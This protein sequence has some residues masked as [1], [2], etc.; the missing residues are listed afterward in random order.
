MH[1]KTGLQ[2]KESFGYPGWG[3]D[4]NHH[5]YRN[6]IIWKYREGFEPKI[7]L[8]KEDDEEGDLKLYVPK[9]NE[10]IHVFKPLSKEYRIRITDWIQ[11]TNPIYMEEIIEFPPGNLDSLKQG[12]EEILNGD[13]LAKI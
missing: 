6:C 10:E 7:T 8:K 4:E 13:F 12:S 3:E 2:H 9:E 11:A 5:N 1:H